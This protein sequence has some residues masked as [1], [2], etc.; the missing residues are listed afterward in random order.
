MRPQWRRCSGCRRAASRPGRAAPRSGG[1]SASGAGSGRAWSACGAGCGPSSGSFWGRSPPVGWG[2][3][4]CLLAL[5]EAERLQRPGRG[6]HRRDARWR[7]SVAERGVRRA[8]MRRGRHYATSPSAPCLV[9]AGLDPTSG[10]GGERVAVGLGA[11]DVCRRPQPRRPRGTGWEGQPMG[12]SLNGNV[13]VRPPTC[14]RTRLPCSPRWPRSRA[15]TGAWTSWRRRGD[16]RRGRGRFIHVGAEAVRRDGGEKSGIGWKRGF[17]TSLKP[18]LRVT[19]TCADP[20]AR[21]FS[22]CASPSPRPHAALAVL[23]YARAWA[24]GRRS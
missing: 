12:A 1:A 23:T 22:W 4:G 21:G 5:G 11:L 3:R 19:A 24:T 15:R 18:E 7:H 10:G 14:R 2:A 6:G 9:G 8:E 20:H 13:F 16:Q 17:V